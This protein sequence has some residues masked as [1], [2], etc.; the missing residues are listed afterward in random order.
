MLSEET[1]AEIAK[2]TF[3]A[4]A[5]LED[6]KKPIVEHRREL[7]S[8]E[9]PDSNMGGRLSKI[10]RQFADIDDRKAA[11]L[12]LLRKKLADVLEHE[13]QRI[14]A[15][16]ADAVDRVSKSYVTL[17]A[18]DSVVG[19]SG[20]GCNGPLHPGWKANP[21]FIPTDGRLD[22]LKAVGRKTDYHGIAGVAG[23]LLLRESTE[24]AREIREDLNQKIGDRVFK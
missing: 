9:F 19:G 14:A 1:I 5:A 21:L 15:E 7:L 6:E 2:P 11:A 8:A 10:T 23:S 20:P 17:L 12:G 16:Y 18:L 24:L 22:A 13:M 4:I 3:D